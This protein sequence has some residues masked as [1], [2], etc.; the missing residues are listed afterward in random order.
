MAGL[1]TRASIRGL[2]K[3]LSLIGGIQSRAGN[4]APL[5]K[6]LA[7]VAFK[8]VMDH[9]SEE[10][11]PEGRWKPLSQKTIDRR[12]QGPKRGRGIRILQDEGILRNS[13]HPTSPNQHQEVRIEPRRIILR[14]NVK[15]ASTHEYGRSGIPARRFMWVSVGARQNMADVSAKWIARAEIK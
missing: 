8:D 5:F 15:Y 13:L 12:R 3:V 2:S 10:K 1:E 7:V 9:F 6:R 11:A 4:L 14:T